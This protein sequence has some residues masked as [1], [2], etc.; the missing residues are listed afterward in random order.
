[1]HSYEPPYTVETSFWKLLETFPS[2]TDWPAVRDRLEAKLAA[3]T[4]KNPTLTWPENRMLVGLRIRATYLTSP[5]YVEM[6]RSDPLFWVGLLGGA[7]ARLCEYP[8]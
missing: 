1:M 3:G 6:E 4:T 7:G 8:E 5:L 2:D